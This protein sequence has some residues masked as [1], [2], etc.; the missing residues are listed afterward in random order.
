MTFFYFYRA[1]IIVVFFAVCVLQISC[2]SPKAQYSPFAQ[3][4]IQQMESEQESNQTGDKALS[5]E[6]Q[7]E[8]L[9][10]KVNDIYVVKG[11]IVVDLGFKDSELEP[12]NVVVHSKLDQLWTVEIPITSL[13]DLGTVKGVHFIEIDVPVHKREN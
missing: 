2:A 3:R 6:T 1:V 11:S 12:F 5:K 8:F 13:K 4:L 9:V 7:E 10:K